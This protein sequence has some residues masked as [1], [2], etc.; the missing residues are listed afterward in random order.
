[1]KLR[2]FWYIAAESRQ[3]NT[4]RAHSVQI[5]GVHLALYRADNGQAV[6]I[7]DRCLHRAAQLS[8]GK[9]CN[10]QI[11]CPYHGWTYNGMGE[12][13]DIPSVC[14]SEIGR[15]QA[16]RFPVVEKQGY[17]YVWLDAEHEPDHGPFSIPAYG[18]AGYHHI[19]LVNSFENTVTNCVENFVDIPHTV[20]VHPGIFRVRR[21]QKLKAHI[22]RR[23]G[24]VEVVYYK[25]TANLGF[26]SWFLNP[27]AREIKH[28]DR[29]YMPNITSVEYDMGP[30]R[31]FYISSQA[32]PV[33]ERRTLVYTD[34][35]YNYG[36]W[37]RLAAPI[38]RLQGQAIINQDKQILK[39]QNENLLRFGESFQN[40]STDLIHIFIESIRHALERE[41]DPRLLPVKTKEIEF[42]V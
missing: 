14:P 23:A 8:K 32:I 25:E 3:L 24:K 33:E 10:G 13:V 2:Q 30:K 42:W 34:L 31:H 7:E 29:F 5:L 19:R 6:A 17:I 35:T 40:T 21:N 9:V 38:V 1:M 37:N 41:E 26:F 28:I 12:V 39:N 22:T 16:K 18:K 15:R 20:F 11:V 36:I 27:K 4:K